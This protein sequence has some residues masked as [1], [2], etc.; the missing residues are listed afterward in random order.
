[1]KYLPAFQTISA[2]F[3]YKI[4]LNSQQYQVRLCWNA[5][6]GHWFLTIVDSLGGRI[7]GVKVVEKWPL[8]TPHRAQIKMSGDIVAIPATASATPL[9]YDNLGTEWLLAYMTQSEL[10]DWKANNGVG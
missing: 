1:M 10:L 6:C 7:D 3:T 2:D 4:A 8:L 5:R 9:G